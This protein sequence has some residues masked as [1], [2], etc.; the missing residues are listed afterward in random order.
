MKRIEMIVPCYNEEPCIVPLY[1]AVE[2]VFASIKDYDWSLLYINDGSSDGTLAELKKLKADKGERVQY[3]SF[4]RNFGKE[5]AIYAGL[6]NSTGEL[7]VLMDADLQHPPELIPQMIEGIEEGYDCCGARRVSRKG[8]P[9]IRSA[10]SRMF[11]STIN[12]MTEMR[13]VQGGSDF[14]CMTRQMVDSILLLT[15]RERF[16]K[17]IMSWVGFETKWIPYENVERLAGKS[18]WNFF[19]LVRYALSGFI[20]FATAPLRAMIY[21]GSVIVAAAVVYAVYLVY[22]AI[23]YPEN[24][25]SGFGTI[26]L[27][28][29]FFGGV[30]VTLLGIIGEYVARIYM[31]LKHRPIYIEK[32]NTTK[33][34]E[35]DS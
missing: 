8:E 4:A 1:E 2:K 20:A 10:F 14:R 35:K 27:L 22:N 17:G 18:K 33:K 21:F 30:L 19:G 13:L 5:S 6:K 25:G 29:L 23:R 24:N 26:V 12:H 28:I 31:E 15:E 34:Q 16:S 11:Y 9:I 32:I 3:I 7:V